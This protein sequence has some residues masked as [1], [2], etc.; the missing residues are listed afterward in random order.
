MQISAYYTLTLTLIVGLVF[1]T[2]Q[3]QAQSQNTDINNFIGKW[4]YNSPKAPYAYQEGHL[5]IANENEEDHPTVT[6]IFS[7]EKK[8]EAENVKLVDQKLQFSI[9]VENEYVTVTLKRQDDKI[10]GTADTT[11]DKLALTAVRE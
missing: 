9:Y 10:T 5:L 1:A 4:K 8:L 2:S 7:E 11:S 6:I 3:V